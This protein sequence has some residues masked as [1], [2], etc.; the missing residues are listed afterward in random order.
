MGIR[1]LLEHPLTRGLSVDDPRTTDLRHKII[2][3]KTFLKSIYSEWYQILLDNLKTSH[4][5]L[6][7]GS[8]AGFIKT[9]DSRVIT[10]EILPVRGVDLVADATKLPF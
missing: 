6:E 1:K 7:L 10:S 4:D 2:Q 3:E 8:G 9:L 5:I